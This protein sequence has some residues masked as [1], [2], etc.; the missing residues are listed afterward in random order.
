MSEPG[1]FAETS[2]YVKFHPEQFPST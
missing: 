2:F 1:L